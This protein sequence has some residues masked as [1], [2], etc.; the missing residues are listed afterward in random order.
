MRTAGEII[1]EILE[2]D[3]VSQS[4]LAEM[5]D[6]DRRAIYQTLRKCQDIK[7]SKFEEML[8]K[9]GYRI[10]IEK[11]QQLWGCF[12]FNIKIHI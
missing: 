5:M 9:L 4:D 1:E 3:G 10:M 11:K 6:T 2:R 8:D 7:Y 12:F